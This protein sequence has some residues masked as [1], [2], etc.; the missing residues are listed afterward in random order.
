MFKRAIQK[1]LNVQYFLN[2]VHFN[3]LVKA[4][5]NKKALI[6]EA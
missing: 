5:L 6:I 1:Y 2:F 4:H 3:K